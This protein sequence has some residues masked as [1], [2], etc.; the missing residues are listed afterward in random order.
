MQQSRIFQFIRNAFV[1]YVGILAFSIL[2]AA[3]GNPISFGETGTLLIFTGGL[4]AF[5]AFLFIIK[6]GVP[7]A[8]NLGGNIRDDARFR[9]ERTSEKTFEFMVFSVIFA[10]LLAVLTGY[11]LLRLG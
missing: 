7:G 4:F 6:T 1:V 2:M 5:I 9:E 3:L 11:V 10:S 8:G